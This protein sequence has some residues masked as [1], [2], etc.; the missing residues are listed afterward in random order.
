MKDAGLLLSWLWAQSIV[1]FATWY[2][3]PLD[4][5]RRRLMMQNG[6][7]KQEM[8]YKGSM[9]CAKKIYYEEGFKAFYK[10]ALINVFRTVGGAMVLVMYEAV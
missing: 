7:V 4:T 8:K 6:K 3:Y 1:I 9:D 10:G 2:I 5:L